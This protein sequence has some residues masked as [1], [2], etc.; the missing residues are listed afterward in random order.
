MIIFAGI[1]GTSA[2][3]ETY[4]KTFANSF[5]NR[6]SRN[7]FVKFDDTFYHRGPYTWGTGTRALAQLAFDWVVNNWNTG[8]VDAVFLAGYSR[9]AAAVTEVTQWLKPLGI[10]VDCLILFD[11]VDRSISVPLPKVPGF[12]GMPGQ[13]GGGVGGIFENTKIASNVKETIHPMRDIPSALSRV[14]FQRCAQ[15][16]E[17]PQMPHHKKH[18]FVTH[19]GAGGTPWTKAENPY[20]GGARETIWEFGEVN[21]TMLTPTADD[22]GAR[23]VETWT[24]PLIRAAFDRCVEE[25]NKKPVEGIPVGPGMPLVPGGPHPAPGVPGGGRIHVVKPGDWLS[26]IAIT[27]YGDMNRWKEIHQANIDVIGPDPNR[28][29]VGQKLVIP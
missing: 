3:E 18:F 14:S 9:G 27:Y 23:F 4:Q 21:P 20:L 22:M 17:D 28:I 5:V 25:K 1:D 12:S 8:N 16:Q 11:A 26:K 29:E 10:P 24:F 15:K 2:E 13:I 6:L 7:E 19:G